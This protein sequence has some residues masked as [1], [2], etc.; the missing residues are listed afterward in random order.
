M[1]SFFSTKPVIKFGLISGFLLVL[2]ELILYYATNTN[3]YIG[4]RTSFF[5]LLG[6]L[7]PIILVV[8]TLVYL[9]KHGTFNSFG[10]I[11]KPGLIVG[12]LTA[13][14]YIIYT[15]L[16]VYNIEP[17]TMAKFEQINRERLLAS[18]QFDKTEDLNNAVQLAN[19]AFL[20]GTILFSIAINLFIGFITA[21]ITAIFVRNK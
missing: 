2:N 14:V 10:E 11:I 3:P 15:L 19:N 13:L 20:P 18:G 21:I 4:E 5:S 1:N 16:F 6:L 9:K 7:I 17:D 8:I 12:F